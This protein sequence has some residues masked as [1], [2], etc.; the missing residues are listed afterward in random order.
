MERAGILVCVEE[1]KLRVVNSVR[2]ETAKALEEAHRELL[3]SNKNYSCIT[4]IVD[5]PWAWEQID[6]I[7]K[8]IG[9]YTSHST[10]I[11]RSCIDKCRPAIRRLG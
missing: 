11:V 9:S 5:S 2:G 8:C 1:D 7:K 4:Y 6:C 3:R 10:N